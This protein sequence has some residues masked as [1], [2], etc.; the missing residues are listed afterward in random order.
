M[1]GARAEKATRK[2]RNNCVRGARGVWPR[3]FVSIA[4]YQRS[5]ETRDPR[6]ALGSTVGLGSLLVQNEYRVASGLDQ[7]RETSEAVAVNVEERAWRVMFFLFFLFILV[8]YW[9]YNEIWLF[10]YQHIYIRAYRTF[11]ATSMP[12]L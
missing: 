2:T 11:G 10:P 4:R 9:K 12:S 1:I 7:L 5:T 8:P 3:D 6:K